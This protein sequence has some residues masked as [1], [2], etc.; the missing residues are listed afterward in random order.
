M[1][2]SSLERPPPGEIVDD[3]LEAE[4]GRV[5]AVLGGSARR[6]SW[7]PPAL[8]KVY[9]LMGGVLLDFREAS[10]F[11]GETVVEVVALMG[12]VTIVV[13]PEIDVQTDGTG[14]LGGF[15]SVSNLSKQ[16][17]APLLRIRGVA[18]LGGVDV[19]VQKLPLMRRLLGD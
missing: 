18:I 14:L 4:V 6:G 5:V 15:S 19:K 13:P 8:L 16:A 11:E 17:D 3:E 12:G 10:L 7:E 2:G 9:A 1:S